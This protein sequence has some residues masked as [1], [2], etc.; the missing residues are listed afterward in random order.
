MHARRH[1]IATGACVLWFAAGD[2]AAA[3]AGLA[4]GV[5]GVRSRIAA[6]G[7]VQLV[8]ADEQ[9]RLA[10]F[11]VR[12]ARIEEEL[13]ALTGRIEQLEFGQR[14]LGARTFH[15]GAAASPQ[16]PPARR[17]LPG[18]RP[19]RRTYRENSAA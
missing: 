2:V 8:Q 6:A 5:D 3:G 17:A 4:A 12:L 10:R 18:A 14:A 11:E 1:L 9:G 13:R 16:A 15:C 19:H 7:P